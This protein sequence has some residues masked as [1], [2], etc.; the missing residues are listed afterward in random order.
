[1]V[2]LL[3]LSISPIEWLHADGKHVIIGPLSHTKA[4]TVTQLDSELYFIFSCVSG[5]EFGRNGRH[6]ILQLEETVFNK[7]LQ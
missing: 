1:L 5:T 6:A 3:A 7:W 2:G 4:Y